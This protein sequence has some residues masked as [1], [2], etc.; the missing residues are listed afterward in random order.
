MYLKEG[1]PLEKGK[2]LKEKSEK[3]SLDN[4]Q[5]YNNIIMFST[6]DD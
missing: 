1:T 3:N 6:S 2:I 4:I 5:H